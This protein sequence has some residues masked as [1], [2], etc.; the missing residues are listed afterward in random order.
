MELG[1]PI[2][3]ARERVLVENTAQNVRKYLDKLADK[4]TALGTRWSWELLQNARD[5]AQEQGVNVAVEYSGGRL[6]FQHDGAPFAA[7]EILHLIYHGSTKV[8][9][10]DAIG[11]FGSGF[12]STH[13]L[14]R[15]VRVRGRLQDGQA[16]DFTLDRTG[17]KVE[18][19]HQAME[20]SFADFER[21][22]GTADLGNAS[23]TTEFDYDVDTAAVPLALAGLS[24]M[25]V[26]APLVLAFS[27]E[28]RSVAVH[29][30]AGNWKVQRGSSRRIEDVTLLSIDSDDEVQ[31]APC[32]V[33]IA[34]QHGN[35]AVSVAMVL[36]E[37]SGGLTCLFDPDSPKLFIQFPLVG[38]DKLGLPAAVNCA[39]FKP[40]EDRDGIVLESDSPSGLTNRELVSVAAEQISRVLDVSAQE[41]W[42]GVEALVSLDSSRL[43]DWTNPAWFSQILRSLAESARGKPILRTA[44]GTCVPINESWIPAAASAEQRTTLWTLV[45]EWSGASSRIPSRDL[46]EIWAGNLSNWATLLGQKLEDM[47][48]ALSVT[49]L[50]RLVDEAG[51]I[52]QLRAC[53]AADSSPYKWMSALL[54]L[55]HSSAKTHLFDDCSLLPSQS[56]RLRRRGDLSADGQIDEELKT[57]AI[58]L[59]LDLR[60]SLLDGRVASPQTLALLKT[61][62]ESDALNEVVLHLR[63]ACKGGRLPTSMA[64]GTAELFS[65]ICARD[66]YSHLIADFPVPTEDADEA[67]VLVYELKAAKVDDRPLAPVAIWPE[68]LRLFAPLFPKRRVLAATLST[69]EALAARWPMLAEKGYV[70]I[71]PLYTAHRRVDRFLQRELLPS[72]EGS[73]GHEV[74]QEADM[75]DI[76]FMNEGDI[77][78]VDTARKSPPRAMQLIR[79]MLELSCHDTRA[80]ETIQAE[81][82][83]GDVHNIYRAGWLASPRSRSWIPEPDGKRSHK[84]SAETLLAFLT[85]EPAVVQELLSDQGAKL[86]TALGVKPSDFALYRYAPD[87]ATRVALIQSIG[88]LAKA[89]GNDA[90]RVRELVDEIRDHP[91]IIEAIEKKKAEREAIHRNQRIGK[92]VEQLLVQALEGHDLHVERTGIGSDYAVDSDFIEGEEEVWLELKSANSSTLIEMKATRTDHAKMTPRQ[93]E[94]ACIENDRFALCVVALTD[95]EPTI[96][97]VRANCRFVFGIGEQLRA[98]WGQYESIRAATSEARVHQGPIAIDMTDGQYRFRIAR[99]IWAGGMTLTDAVAVFVSR[100]QP[101]QHAASK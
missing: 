85:N 38:T 4:R 88:D 26:C 50:G 77:G 22:I 11:Q 10:E 18:E 31:R 74:D 35:N 42:K 19:L 71:S 101:A 16:F 5:V 60:A 25:R 33:A 83:C 97:T 84:V 27:P 64:R 15:T 90:N 58:T 57:I 3:E 56:G 29:G 62:K 37:Q 92:L 40:Q 23:W 79:L 75:S 54:Q 47:P 51:S 73:S 61:K 95:E 66:G 12:L 48:E 99:E 30:E 68:S 8:E 82:A 7:D 53:L 21:S 87:E 32:F 13:L 59:G 34:D 76:A 89:A 28:I 44:A 80:F 2:R 81:C 39:L 24:Q 98:V 67:S 100:A 43:P 55:I 17:Q 14:S 49:R 46:A 36:N 93:A 1:N 70:H 94:T 72:V 63:Q 96:E 20:R 91:E 65:W 52:D 6:R 9:R 86:L 45:S 41:G 69:V 78:L